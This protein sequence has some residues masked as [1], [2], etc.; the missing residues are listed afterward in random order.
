ML[1]R[2]SNQERFQI[3]DGS[4]AVTLPEGE[5]QLYVSANGIEYTAK[6]DK[7]TGPDTFIVANAPK[8]LLCFFDG[9]AEDEEVTVL[10]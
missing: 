1:K 9:I 10:L 7:I 8:G 2:V 3:I 4:M 5:Y 6:G